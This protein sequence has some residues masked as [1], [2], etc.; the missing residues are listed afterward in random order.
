MCVYVCM[1]VCMCSVGMWVGV[2]VG[3]GWVVACGYVVCVC[4][5]VGGWVWLWGVVAASGCVGMSV[6]LRVP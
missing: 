3:G 4:G 6:L 2:S 5:W 1:C